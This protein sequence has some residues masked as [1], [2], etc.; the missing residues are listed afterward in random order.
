MKIGIDL[1]FIRPDHKNGGTEAFMKNLIRGFE[2]LRQQGAMRD[3]IVYFIHRDIYED[4]QKIFPSLAYRIYDIKGPHALRTVWFQTWMLSRLV[5]KEKLDLLYFPTFQTGLKSRWKLPLVVNPNDIQYKYYPEYF[6]RFKRCYFQIFYGNALRKA[7]RLVA[8]SN[9]VKHSYEEHFFKATKGKMRVLYAPI[10]FQAA[11]EEPV[12]ALA[13]FEGE[14]I[15][16]INSLTRHK[17]LITLVRAF[18]LL[19]KSGENKRLKLVIGGAQW[20]GANEIADYIEQNGLKDAVIL[21]GFLTDGQLSYLYHHARLFVT[22]S[23]YE[24]FGMTPIE[25]MAAECPVIS[26]KE[27]SLYE[28]T[29]GLAHYYEPATDEEAL[30]RAIREELA[31]DKAEIV[32]ELAEHKKE[33]LCYSKEKVA[34]RYLELFHETAGIEAEKAAADQTEIYEKLFM[35]VSKEM[36]KNG[37]E[38]PCTQKGFAMNIGSAPRK[39]DVA[40]MLELERDEFIDALW[41]TCFQKLPEKE[42]RQQ[43]LGKDRKEI[44]QTASAQGAFAVRGMV[45]VRNPY[46]RQKYHIKGKMLSLA[47]GVKNSVFLRKLAKKMPG[48]L[49]KRIRKLFC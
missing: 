9:Y 18:H 39:V 19:L 20:N 46:F 42:R 26:S 13:D 11:D 12:E 14:Y 5:K 33:M 2:A 49:Q 25:A 21:T 10:D 47:A 29:K 41:L 28:V 40:P 6:S 44:L 43:M 27:T 35:S 16:C 17:N 24:G 45:L 4:Y 34:G 48:G 22:P 8:L 38:L 32:G 7:D 3:E 36:E 15:L 1:S 37:V 31:A 30:C 23:L